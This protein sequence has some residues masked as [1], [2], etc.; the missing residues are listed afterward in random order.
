MPGRRRGA[1]RL[2]WLRTVAGVLL[3][4]LAA[5]AVV[6]PWWWNHRSST[7]GGVLL[8][9]GLRDPRG[10][11]KSRGAGGCGASAS[12]PR[13]ATATAARPGVLAIPS[14]GLTAPVVNG[15]GTSVLDVAVGHDPATV[16]PGTPGESVLLAHDVSY[17]SGLSR[18]EIG[19]SV[20]W[21]LGCS[22]MVFR[23]SATEV[24][25]PGASLP[26]PGSGSGL[27]LVTCW[28]TNALFWTSQRFVVNT[29]LVGTETLRSPPS[30]REPVL[31]HPKVPAPPALAAEGL[32]LGQS[33]IV[34]GKLA[35]TG[36]PSAAFE[37]GPQPLAIEEAVMEDYAAAAKTAAAG[38]RTWWSTLALPGVT[39]PEPWPTG[40]ST[41]V[42][43]VVSGSTVKRVV[44]SSPGAS[45][46]LVMRGGE[47][48]VSRVAPGA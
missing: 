31:T 5:T 45:L 44:V 40:Y 4:A 1:G 8:Q 11:A 41:D 27:A 43:L 7:E 17:F 36:S 29:T 38:N 33:G 3:L 46:T 30:R 19:D 24:T 15:M 12:G 10:A 34:V 9:R 37:E 28:P 25:T 2:L 14:I 48:L 22:E 18:L 6:Y 42:T 20:V 47:L 16:W 13:T 23:V 32:A 26:V 21:K 35:I 39:L